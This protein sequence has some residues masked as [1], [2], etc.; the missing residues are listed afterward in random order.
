MANT[1]NKN[2]PHAYGAGRC[3]AAFSLSHPG[4]V[5]EDDPDGSI[6]A[7]PPGLKTSPP[8]GPQESKHFT[9]YDPL[10][11]AGQ[12]DATLTFVP[13]RQP[14]N[15]TSFGVYVTGS[16]TKPLPYRDA[17]T[18]RVPPAIS[19]SLN[20]EL[21]ANEVRPFGVVDQTNLGTTHGQVVVNCVGGEG[22]S[23]AEFGEVWYEVALNWRVPPAKVTFD[24]SGLLGTGLDSNWMAKKTASVR[25]SIAST[26]WATASYSDN[27][28]SECHP[29]LDNPPFGGTDPSD[30][31]T[32]FFNAYLST[33]PSMSSY[34]E[35][36]YGPRL[37]V[38][39]S[40][41]TEFNDGFVEPFELKSSSQDI[42]ASFPPTVR[43]EVT[44]KTTLNRWRLE[45][46]S[47][48]LGTYG[49]NFKGTLE[50]E[51]APVVR[52]WVL[53]PSVEDLDIAIPKGLLRYRSRPCSEE[54]DNGQ[55]PCVNV[56][57][58]QKN[59][60]AV[61]GTITPVYDLYDDWEDLGDA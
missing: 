34:Y 5:P 14:Y 45:D 42:E 4:G 43:A 6:L 54:E 24:A 58:W 10:A 20:A 51:F 26:L 41:Y 44:L 25:D 7:L 9:P 56:S 13:D 40:E 53:W 32:T 33:G 59:S 27:G 3:V 11:P 23:P 49:P 8:A 12:G 29:Q 18:P 35:M 16:G 2:F 60:S 22:V 31:S 30:V 57:V 46:I 38:I 15:A 17:Y 48:D 61:D 47:A 21:P 50:M 19:A 55:V 36:P 37:G 39:D 28:L 52:I 1:S